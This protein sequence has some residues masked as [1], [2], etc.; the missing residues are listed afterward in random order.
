[1][2]DLSFLNM[3]GE[4]TEVVTAWEQYD[5]IKN[6]NISYE[7]KIN[8]MKCLDNPFAIREVALWYADTEFYAERKIE[9]NYLKWIGK[10]RNWI[11]CRR[12]S[13][14]G[15]RSAICNKLLA[16]TYEAEGLIYSEKKDEESR[17]KAIKYLEKSEELL[18][19]NLV[20][21]IIETE[22]GRISIEQRH[23]TNSV[24]KRLQSGVRA[25]A[26][27]DIFSYTLFLN[28]LSG[29]SLVDIKKKSEA[30]AKEL[31]G[32]QWD[33]LH[34]TSKKQIITALYTLK[35][36]EEAKGE[37]DFDYSAIVSLLSRALEY[38]IK[39]RFY[40]GYLRF[41]RSEILISD[42][43]II[44]Q[45]TKIGEYKERKLIVDYTEEED[46]SINV[47][48]YHE[49]DGVGEKEYTLGSINRPI[50]FSYK[51]NVSGIDPT[52]MDYCKKILWDA[53]CEDAEII[54]WVT[55]ICRNVLELREVRNHA[56]HGGY[57]L[58]KD[59]AIQA[60]DEIIL[61]GKILVKLLEPCKSVH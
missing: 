10:L 44:N 49:Y 28:S 8:K 7:C 27:L 46:G 3:Q 6:E 33:K 24:L 57:N 26:Y 48:G 31:I 56:S 55:S 32:E 21:F 54:D 61:I 2:K 50:G 13:I 23:Q 20:E 42:Y 52:F 17:R 40:K 51:T 18:S 34:L 37:S 16:W 29:D 35:V 38:E 25:S 30:K 4:P 47:C 41:L 15:T 53:K 59:E 5:R 12:N 43:V 14:E 60:F 9:K 1:M 19:D 58:N 39:I 45:V 11:E 22:C 36:M